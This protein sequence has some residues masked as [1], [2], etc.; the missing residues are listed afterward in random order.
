MQMYFGR[1]VD[2]RQGDQEFG[3]CTYR[4]QGKT[5]S[6]KEDIQTDGQTDIVETGIHA[7][8]EAY[9]N[10]KDWELGRQTGRHPSWEKNIQF[11]IMFI[12]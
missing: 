3:R 2:R 8:R 5:D 7:A 12:S 9:K 6:R 1:Q 10:T 11:L 4:K